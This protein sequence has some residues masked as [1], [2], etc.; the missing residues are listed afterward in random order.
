[1]GTG[2]TEAAPRP[3]Q[4]VQ[5]VECLQRLRKSVERWNRTGGS[6]GYLGFIR[7]FVA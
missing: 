1:M 3:L 6:R 5:M 4:A 7:Q 2:S